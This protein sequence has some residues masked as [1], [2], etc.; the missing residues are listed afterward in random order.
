[1]PGQPGSSFIPLFLKEGRHTGQAWAPEQETGG[2]RPNQCGR[3][4]VQT[5]PSMIKAQNQRQKR[6]K[7]QPPRQTR[8]RGDNSAAGGHGPP[9]ARAPPSSVSPRT[10]DEHP[11]A[12]KLPP[13]VESISGLSATDPTRLSRRKCP[14]VALGAAGKRWPHF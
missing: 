7:A 2:K 10:S 8:L 4:F 5:L 13:N 14:P 1:M 11:K 12:A 3:S 9:T 6:E